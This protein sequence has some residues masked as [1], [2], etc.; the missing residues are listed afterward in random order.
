MHGN[1]G[2]KHAQKPA[3]KRA[4][5]FL[6]IRATPANKSTWVRAA[7]AGNKKLAAWVTETLN[8]AASD[9]GR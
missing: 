3:E 5:S 4:S 6:H 2:K 7:Q 1:T 9:R 8:E